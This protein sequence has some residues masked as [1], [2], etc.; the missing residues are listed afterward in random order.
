MRLK[1]TS[2]PNWVSSVGS[3]YENYADIVHVA[4]VRRGQSVSVQDLAGQFEDMKLHMAQLL[5][6]RMQRDPVVQH[7]SNGN[8]VRT[9]LD[10]F[11]FKFLPYTTCLNGA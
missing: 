9:S 4:T 8:H 10:V 5:N 1:G 2:S 11:P 3:T 7:G 6:G